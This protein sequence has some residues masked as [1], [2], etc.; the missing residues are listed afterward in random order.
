MNTRERTIGSEGRIEPALRTRKDPRRQPTIM[1]SYFSELH[2]QLL[3]QGLLQ[4]GEQLVGKAVTE[5]KPWWTLGLSWKTFLTLATPERLILVEHRMAWFHAALKLH[6]VESIPWQNVQ[7]TRITGLFKKKV[8]LR[9][10][11]QS[12]PKNIAMTVPNRL[13][14]LLAPMKDN[15]QGARN[16]VGAF[17]AT[18]QL[19]ASQAPASLPPMA[20][21]TPQL[22][23]QSQP[24]APFASV[25][26]VPPPHA[27]LPPA[28]N[29]QGY[30][31]VPPPPSFGG[32]QSV[33]PSQHPFA[34]NGPPAPPNG[35]P[36][37][38]FPQS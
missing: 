8:R 35:Y 22:A 34:A 31:S 33:R 21:A 6:S 25:F 20:Y 12:G 29:A 1:Y 15:M 30:A 38:S 5:Y 36:P 3:A 24:N 14:G 13:F 2:V 11:T 27:A 19:G 18:R 4:P 32:P 26:A 37:R 23:P 9:A 7:E 17:Q 28:I 16:V 10:Q